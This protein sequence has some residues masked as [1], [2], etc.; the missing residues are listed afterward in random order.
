MTRKE[1]RKSYRWS[2]SSN[3]NHVKSMCF[4]VDYVKWLPTARS[5]W[6]LENVSGVRSL[7]NRPVV[8]QNVWIGAWLSFW[9]GRRWII[10]RSRIDFDNIN[11]QS[12]S[13]EFVKEK[14]RIQKRGVTTKEKREATGGGG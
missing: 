12:L 13:E 5:L 4:K 11:R 14:K 3:A 8:T 1:S 9:R 6:L 10:E 7:D 2:W